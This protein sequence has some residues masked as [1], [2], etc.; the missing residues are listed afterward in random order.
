MKIER[1][2]LTVNSNNEIIVRSPL[3]SYKISMESLLERDFR[4]NE[5]ILGVAINGVFYRCEEF[6]LT[7]GK[8]VF[9]YIK[10]NNLGNSVITFQIIEGFNRQTYNPYNS[11]Y[12]NGN[13]I[14]IFKN[15][16]TN[17]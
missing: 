7:N 15:E 16:I 8:K 10:K 13:E 17:Y 6:E 12:Q 5:N 1:G 14:R 11:L 9:G 4:S 2:I 3:H